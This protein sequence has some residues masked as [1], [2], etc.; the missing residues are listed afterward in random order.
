MTGIIGAMDIEVESVISRFSNKNVKTIAGI[1][2]TSGTISGKN[3]V[4]AK[5]NPGKVNAA[6]CAQIM[7]SEFCPDEII[8]IGV[9]GSLDSDL[10]IG[11][12]VIG[13]A[14]IQTDF[15]TSPLGDPVGFVS[16]IDLIEI[17]CAPYITNK[18]EICAN[19]LGINHKC[20]IVSTGDQFVNSDTRK[21]FLKEHFGCITCEM[22]GGAIGHV[23]FINSVPYG[24]IR[25]MS[26]K[27]DNSSHIDFPEFAKMA[28]KN[29][30]AMIEKYMSID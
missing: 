27:A 19:A 8:N 10:D 23:C 21:A 14:A 9:A 12:I 16:G 1:K 6:V 26:D 13:T 5:C 15:D 20:G 3:A 17:E 30:T 2:F 18:L 7:I 11:D 28:C 22:E 4:I 24:I 25:S 29:S